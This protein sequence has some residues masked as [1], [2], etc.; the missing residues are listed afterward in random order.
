MLTDGPSLATSLLALLGAVLLA[1]GRIRVGLWVLAAGFVT[2][3]VVRYSSE[4]LVALVL[5]VAA[6]IC[7][8]WVPSSR[9]R[10]M[11]LLA[12]VSGAGFVV[13]ELAS[14]VLGWPGLSVS[15][16]DTFTKHFIRPD[17]SDPLGRL[18]RLD[19]SFW[20]Y[21]PVYESTALLLAVGLIAIG[22][23][24]LRRDAVFGILSIAIAATGLGAV[25]AH[26]LES[27]ADRLMSP[28][29]VLLALGLPLLFAARRKESDESPLGDGG[30]KPER[31]QES[32]FVSS[33]A[34]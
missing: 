16:Q 22:V 5:A 10:G 1:K 9:G 18:V 20:A 3:F 2:G 11:K 32:A 4:Q 33:E 6:L 27:Q 8:K 28:V 25:I 26:P 12:I 34:A 19:L 31:E 17:V 30:G 14:T 23:A 15:L 24:L 7:L 29:W 21:F 13:S